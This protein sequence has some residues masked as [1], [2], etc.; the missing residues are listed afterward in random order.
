M[1]MHAAKVCRSVGC[2][3]Y[4]EFDDDTQLVLKFLL[5]MKTTTLDRYP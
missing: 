4:F 3:F 1:K 2:V 5:E